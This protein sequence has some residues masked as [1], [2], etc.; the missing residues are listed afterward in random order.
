MNMCVG[1]RKGRK[2][3]EQKS[4]KFE[5][6]KTIFGNVAILYDG[7]WMIRENL[8]M[9][10]SIFEFVFECSRISKYEFRTPKS[11]LF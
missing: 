10:F 9:Y 1:N 8:P 3:K 2:I 4:K 5:K 11:R 7:V 6:R